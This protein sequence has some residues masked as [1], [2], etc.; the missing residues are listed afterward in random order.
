MKEKIEEWIKFF[1]RVLDEVRKMVHDQYPVEEDGSGSPETLAIRK[2][3]ESFSC[4]ITV[5]EI[6]IDLKRY[7]YIKDRICQI[8]CYNL[9]KL[10][11]RSIQ[12]HGLINSRNKEK[13]RQVLIEHFNLSEKG[14]DEF[15]KDFKIISWSDEKCSFYTQFRWY[16][17]S[18]KENFREFTFDFYKD[19]VFFIGGK[20]IER[21]K[22]V[23]DY[24]ARYNLDPD[25]ILSIYELTKKDSTVDGFTGINI[26]SLQEQVCSLQLIP[27]VS[28]HVKRVFDRAKKLFV[29]G[30]FHYG[31]FTI[32]EH[33][34][35]LALESAIRNR[36]N[37]FLGKKAKVTSPEGETVE[38]SSSWWTIYKFCRRK[39]WKLGKTTVNG[40]DFPYNNR[41][42]LN[43]L[44]E[45]NIITKWEKKQ[46]D[47]GINLR[48]ILSHQEFAPIH[49]P[50]SFTLKVIADRINRLFH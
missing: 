45:Q 28:E 2:A 15:Y 18:K 42:L 30:Y 20:L 10:G 9:D 43:W 4:P 33:Y 41:L 39:G 6:V 5:A 27:T 14:F 38:L 11:E 16:D 17:I 13:L 47:V 34:A 25:P 26:Q 31:F 19:F 22:E 23:V 44:V 8:V 3:I 7:P 37:Q 48:N 1:D 40:Q 32:S 49:M 46:Y 50:N 12:Y 29:Y 35:Y 21:F 24:N 36:Y